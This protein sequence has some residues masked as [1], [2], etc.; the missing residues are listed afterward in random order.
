ML[1]KFGRPAQRSFESWTAESGQELMRKCGDKKGTGPIGDR[2]VDV[3]KGF[4]KQLSKLR[5]ISCRGGNEANV[6]DPSREVPTELCTHAPL[7]FFV[8][9]RQGCG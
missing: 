9:Q 6:T 1:R 7:V 5:K 8:T 4:V 3:D 2:W